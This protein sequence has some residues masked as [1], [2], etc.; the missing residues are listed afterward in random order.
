MLWLLFVLA[1]AI[2]IIFSV[3]LVNY[4]QRTRIL[5]YYFL[6]QDLKSKLP[7]FNTDYVTHY[8]AYQ[9][10]RQNNSIA[11]TPVQKG[12]YFCEVNFRIKPFLYYKKSSFPNGCNLTKSEI[13]TWLTTKTA[14]Y[15]ISYGAV[16]GVSKRALAVYTGLDYDTYLTAFF[17]EI[18]DYSFYNNFNEWFMATG[19]DLAFAP[20]DT[21][22]NDEIGI[23]TIDGFLPSSPDYPLF[24]PKF[25]MSTNAKNLQNQFNTV[26]NALK[27]LII[28]KPQ[29]YI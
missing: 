11:L 10:L 14:P 7:Q 23:A 13:T 6:S 27:D 25:I 16:R 5:S 29:L 28:K 22:A 21:L 4:S 24:T 2:I 3:S 1:I 19:V 9:L 15:S 12:T 8:D 18:G 17:G 20:Y 26:E